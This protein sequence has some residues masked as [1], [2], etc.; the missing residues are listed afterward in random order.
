M[1]ASMARAASAY[2]EVQVTSRSPVELVVMLYDGAISSIAQARAAM[3]AR[4][5][6]TKRAAIDKAYAIVTH[7]QSTLSMDDGGEVAAS[8]D[9][10]YTYVVDQ[11]V[12]ANTSL[13]PAPLDDCLRVLRPLRD[14]WASLA[15]QQG[16]DLR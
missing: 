9:S 13:A 16:A 5:L 1:H 10:L 11:I 6:V 2:Q 15:S 12:Q 3:V 4:D 7:L 8:L 14:A